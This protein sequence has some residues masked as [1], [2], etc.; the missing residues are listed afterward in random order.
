MSKSTE[1]TIYRHADALRV[2]RGEHGAH[3]DSGRA[4]VTVYPDAVAAYAMEKAADIRAAL[5]RIDPA[6]NAPR[7]KVGAFKPAPVFASIRNEAQSARAAA[8]ESAAH[9]AILAA[10][11][12][13]SAE[14]LAAIRRA[15]YHLQG[16][17][18]AAALAVLRD[19]Y[20]AADGNTWGAAVLAVGP[21]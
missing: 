17:N 4:R 3:L 9:R 15:A 5:L 2:V 10:P 12:D 11:A 18:A 14:L 6:C 19:A 16:N 8:L 7:V 1:I 13:K 21:L 20:K